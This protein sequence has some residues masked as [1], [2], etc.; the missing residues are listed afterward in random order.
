MLRQVRSE[1][2]LASNLG[3]LERYKILIEDDTQ[4]IGALELFPR[5]SKLMSQAVVEAPSKRGRQ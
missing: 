3:Q 1:L 5:A 4:L 2:A